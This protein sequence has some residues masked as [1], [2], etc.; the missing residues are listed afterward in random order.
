MYRCTKLQTR[1][2]SSSLSLIKLFYFKMLIIASKIKALPKCT[3]DK[4]ADLFA[5]CYIKMVLRGKKNK[6]RNRRRGR[7]R[8]RALDG[9]LTAVARS[10][11]IFVHF[12]ARD[13]ALVTDRQVQ[14]KCPGP[15]LDW[16]SRAF[17][18]S[19]TPERN[20][21]RNQRKIARAPFTP[22]RT[23]PTLLSENRSPAATSYPHPGP[24]TVRPSCKHFALPID[25]YIP[26]CRP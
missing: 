4:A 6:D 5:L 19:T 10:L 12:G 9:P 25:R 23:L 18:Q 13:N 7:K 21:G 14:T 1:I 22:A 26:A 16:P 15:P 20:D 24:S 11:F 8:E 2:I 3:V 17:E